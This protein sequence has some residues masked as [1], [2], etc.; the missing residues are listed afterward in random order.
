VCESATQRGR[1]Q[2]TAGKG[3]WRKEEDARV[4]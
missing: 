3:S 4:D 1:V 2:G